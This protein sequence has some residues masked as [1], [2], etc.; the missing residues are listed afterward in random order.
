MTNISEK[1]A[2]YLHILRGLTD[3]FK[4]FNTPGHNALSV[5]LNRVET[6]AARLLGSCVMYPDSSDCLSSVCDVGYLAAGRI[7][8]FGT[9]FLAAYPAG[10]FQK[11]SG[12]VDIP[13]IEIDVKIDRTMVAHHGREVVERDRRNLEEIIE[14]L[15]RVFQGLAWNRVI[16]RTNE[17]LLKLGLS[18]RELPDSPIRGCEQGARAMETYQALVPEVKLILDPATLDQMQGLSGIAAE[19]AYRQAFQERG[20]LRADAITMFIYQEG[21]ALSTALKFAHDNDI[22]GRRCGDSLGYYNLASPE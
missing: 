11:L 19:K 13:L 6:T 16:E 8:Q 4:T 2:G 17:T 21:A 10:S 18:Q 3:A 7:N 9:D 14:G 20:R 1:V 12:L 22:R 15:P 5:E